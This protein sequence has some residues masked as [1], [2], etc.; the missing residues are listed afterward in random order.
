MN[1]L[2]NIPFFSIMIAM[3]SGIITSVLPR[4]KARRLNA[5]MITVVGLLSGALFLYLIV[6]DVGSFTYM[7]GHY[8]AP[9]G[10][11]LRAGPLEAMLSL[12]FCIVMVLSLEGGKRDTPL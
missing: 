10:N 3:F 9:W 5:V 1:F 4:Q 12:I 11:E 6:S 7:M 8:P 2:Q